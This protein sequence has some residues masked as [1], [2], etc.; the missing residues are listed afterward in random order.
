MARKKSTKAD[1]TEQSVP[2]AEFAANVLVAAEQL[3]TPRPC[4]P[5]PLLRWM[6]SSR[7]FIMSE[8]CSH[9]T[10]ASFQCDRGQK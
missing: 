3:S 9:S 4:G 6:R 10:I 2:L 1:R 5:S 7:R 8:A